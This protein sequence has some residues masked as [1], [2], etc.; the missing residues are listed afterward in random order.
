LTD[1]QTSAR[2]LMLIE[3]N[4]EEADLILFLLRN[5]IGKKA[6][7]RAW[8]QRVGAMIHLNDKLIKQI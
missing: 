4:P 8:T 6:A 5:Q 7:S 2:R 3:V 1:R